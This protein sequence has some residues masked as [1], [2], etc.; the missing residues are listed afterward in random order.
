MS[1]LQQ[2]IDQN[3]YI[4]FGEIAS[5]PLNEDE[6][7]CRE[8][9]TI[10]KGL[11][12]YNY[13]IDGDFGGITRQA[14][15][16]F[17]E[18]KGLTGGDILGPSTAKALLRYSTNGVL[19]PPP[20]PPL[21]DGLARAVI[22]EGQKHGLTLRTQIAYIMATVQHET[23]NT[24][25]PVR[26]AFWKTEEWRRQN[27]RYY[28]YYGRGYVQ[29]TWRTNYQ[30]YSNILGVDLVNNPDR[31]LEPSISLYILVHGMANGIFTGRRLGQ[32]VSVNRTDFVNARKVINDMDRAHHIANLAQQWLTKLNNFPV[33]EALPEAV[34]LGAGMPAFI[35][36]NV[37]LSK[38]EL[39]LFEQ[40][41]SS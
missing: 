38:D 28:P 7:L 40:I 9:Q 3:K 17:K 37:Q 41:M 39:L 2:V 32:Y 19:P 30:K 35:D 15:R 4:P 33:P 1:T 18:E 21:P 5:S 29:L 24:Y 8:I 13:T 11:N 36:E 14:L 22:Q 10:L 25:K 16:D 23:A 27:L 6:E 26:E 34:N 20:Q 31:A 12:L